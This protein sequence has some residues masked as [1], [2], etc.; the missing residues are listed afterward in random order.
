MVI[1]TQITE[2]DISIIYKSILIIFILLKNE[3]KFFQI[4]SNDI[5]LAKKMNVDCYNLKGEIYNIKITHENDMK[6]ADLIISSKKN[7]IK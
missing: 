2:I 1:V 7:D 4:K 6:I 5:Q 3:T